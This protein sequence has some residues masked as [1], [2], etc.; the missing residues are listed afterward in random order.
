MALYDSPPHVANILSSA[1][2][3]DAGGGTTITYTAVQSGLACSISTAS[4]STVLMYAQNQ[5]QVTHT[6]AV[7]SRRLSQAVAPGMKVTDGDGLSYHVEG[8][9]SGRAYGTIPAFTYLDLRQLL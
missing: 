2:S 4:A 6:L 3:V 9:R 5:V 8:I 7:E 1:T